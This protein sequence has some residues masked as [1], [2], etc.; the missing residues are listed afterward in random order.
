MTGG[1]VVILGSFG[2]NIGAGMTG[3]EAFAYDPSHL[4]AGRLNAQLV[5]AGR[6]DEEQ[7][8]RL[9]DLLE[10]HCELTGSSTAGALLDDWDAAVRRFRRIA[11]VGEV[12]R[13]ERANEGVIG[14]AR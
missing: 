7:A 9:R 5:E 10:C 11:P 12:A 2:Y 1:T 4:L 8:P 3:G 14:A 6:V 13:I